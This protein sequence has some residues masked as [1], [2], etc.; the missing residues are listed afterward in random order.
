MDLTRNIMP[1]PLQA[2]GKIATGEMP[3]MT[4]TEQMM[5]ASGLTVTP[6][7]D[8]AQKLASKLASSHSEQGPVDPAELRKHQLMQEYEFQLQEGKI[9]PED[10]Y[11]MTEDGHI[12]VQEAKRIIR[13]A[14]DT[15]GMDPDLGRLYTQVSHLNMKDFLQVWAVM[16]DQE[17]AATAALLTKKKVAYLKTA[18]KS[19][20]PAER[21]ADPTYTWIRST[22]PLQAPWGE[23]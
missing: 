9:R 16:N 12:S 3:Q 17:K 4:S 19:M 11:Q 15:T 6:F 2:V 21:K 5:Q 23:E 8:E 1:I 14:H 7:R 22:F 10:I 18:M 20:T 13:T